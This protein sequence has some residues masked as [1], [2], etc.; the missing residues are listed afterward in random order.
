MS[1]DDE[2]QRAIEHARRAFAPP[3]AR[4]LRLQAE[5]R[6]KGGLTSSGIARFKRMSKEEQEKAIEKELKVVTEKASK[7]RFPTQAK[8]EK[9]V[10]TKPT[11]TT[12]QEITKPELTF[13]DVNRKLAELENQKRAVVTTV[14]RKRE[15][16]RQQE[17]LNKYMQSRR[18]DLTESDLKQIGSIFKLKEPGDIAERVDTSFRSAIITSGIQKERARQDE[19]ILSNREAPVLVRTVGSLLALPAQAKAET[20]KTSREVQQVV[21]DLLAEA[22][23]KGIREST[24]Q[25]LLGVTDIPK[26]II[27]DIG[28]LGRAALQGASLAFDPRLIRSRVTGIGFEQSP[29]LERRIREARLQTP[30]TRRAAATMGLLGLSALPPLRVPAA[31][32]FTGF[33]ALKTI[34]QPT[35][36]N[37]GTLSFFL[38]TPVAFAGAR[39]LRR[40][41]REI[42]L[43]REFKKLVDPEF[44]FQDTF[45]LFPVVKKGKV[46][47]IMSRRTGIAV[48]Q[49][50]PTVEATSII[51][52]KEIQTTLIRPKSVA[53]LVAEASEKF[54]GLPESQ[55]QRAVNQYV[56]SRVQE[57]IIEFMPKTEPTLALAKGRIQERLFGAGQRTLIDQPLTLSQKV[58]LLR[59]E[60]V[61][62]LI[63][64]R[65]PTDRQVTLRS[66]TELDP[67]IAGFLEFKPQRRNIIA[68]ML[69]SKGGSVP[70]TRT[71]VRV[72]QQQ[73]TPIRREIRVI[74][75]E[76]LLREQPRITPRIIETVAL[77]P[78]LA[79]GR[80]LNL[81]QSTISAQIPII[82]LREENPFDILFKSTL[83]QRPDTREALRIEQRPRQ[84][85]IQLLGQK[86]A[87]QQITQQVQTTIPSQKTLTTRTT[88]R[89]TK[90]RPRSRPRPKPRIPKLP[91]I[92]SESDIKKITKDG[93]VILQPFTAY[94]KRKRAKAGKGKFLDKGFVK[95]AD[96]ITRKAALGA[97]MQQA[98]EYTNRSIRV[99]KTTGTAIKNKRLEKAYE[100]LKNKFRVSKRSP[101][102]LV[103]K[104]KFAID[105][106]N[107]KLGIPL[108]ARR[109]RKRGELS[110]P[111]KRKRG[112]PKK[113]RRK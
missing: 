91:A 88:T 20:V 76:S 99:V 17:L 69:R 22:R 71:G 73:R 1:D 63:I 101:N 38:G 8:F 102:I 92:T 85:Q 105:S 37:V 70:L 93:K 66:F 100:R 33:Q 50:L 25:F 53:Q 11:V 110:M 106:K 62:P 68:E 40:L 4:Q 109:L 6:A 72:F 94:V 44:K 113:K 49:P 41:Q 30:E 87:Q 2:R 14:Q 96:K 104:S 10:I 23:A 107:E 60:G 83:S 51:R 81:N 15:I 32:I 82:N 48:Q 45:Q 3:T 111:K 95:V 27:K 12:Q 103:E 64:K 28:I 65:L 36:R 59:Q 5:A 90:P 97:A 56:I 80:S 58:Q 39:R 78:V 16:Q 77:P 52:P 13:D 61:D 46:I 24:K 34:R 19:Q 74:E 86:L 112:R 89:R 9:Q 84:K 54:K 98:D 55:F 31:A 57:P 21:P 47:G 75:P 26:E 35:A 43:Q 42:R 7:Q 108:E 67:I 18:D 29:E 79:T